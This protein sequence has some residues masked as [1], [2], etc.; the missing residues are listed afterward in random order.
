MLFFYSHTKYHVL[1]K[2]TISCI[3]QLISG[4]RINFSDFLSVEKNPKPI[5]KRYFFGK[6][7]GVVLSKSS[8]ELIQIDIN[9]TK[10]LQGFVFM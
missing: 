7:P 3:Y 9:E 5:D 4:D 8:A 10:I 2:T 1:V 6:E